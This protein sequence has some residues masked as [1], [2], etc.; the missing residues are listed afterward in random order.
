M[1][2][3]FRNI[4]EQDKCHGSYHKNEEWIWLHDTSKEIKLDTR[5]AEEIGIHVTMKIN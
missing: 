5:D 4:K 2:V 3:N 1:Y